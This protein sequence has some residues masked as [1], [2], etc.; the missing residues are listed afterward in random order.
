MILLIL[1][2]PLMLHFKI[3][4]VPFIKKKKYDDYKE[5]ISHNHKIP[6]VALMFLSPTSVYSGAPGHKTREP[7]D[8]RAGDMIQV[9]P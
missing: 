2:I 4:K 5:H 1:C 8:T 3:I 7:L 6:E 9:C